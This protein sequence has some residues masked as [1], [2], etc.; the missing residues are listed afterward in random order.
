M[1]AL[2]SC[3]D[4]RGILASIHA[5][6]ARHTKEERVMFATAL[7][8]WIGP[9]AALLAW[10]ATHISAAGEREMSVRCGAHRTR[11]AWQGKHDERT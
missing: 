6:V 5:S 3:H 1:G 11:L 2:C 8:P 7:V 10:L 9:Y 4:C